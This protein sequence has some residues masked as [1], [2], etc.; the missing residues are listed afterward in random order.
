MEEPR[1]HSGAERSSGVSPSVKP[2]SAAVWTDLLQLET[3]CDRPAPTEHGARSAA[4]QDATGP[5]SPGKLLLVSSISAVFV[6]AAPGA[7]QLV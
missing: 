1:C 5:D 4:Q 3:P 6:F 7:K 2:L